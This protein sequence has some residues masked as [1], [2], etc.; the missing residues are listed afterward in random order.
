M[1][2]TSPIPMPGEEPPATW[3]HEELALRSWTSRDTGLSGNSVPIGS[4]RGRSCAISSG[5]GGEPAERKL[6]GPSSAQ[7]E[8]GVLLDCPPGLLY[9]GGAGPSPYALAR[10]MCGASP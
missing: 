1:A 9:P 4:G 2:S 10:S 5:N 7:P 8:P 3:I 6:A